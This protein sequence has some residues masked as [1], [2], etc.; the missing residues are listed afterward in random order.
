M[1]LLKTPSWFQNHMGNGERRPGPK[2][3]TPDYFRCVKFRIEF[4]GYCN[5]CK[6]Q[7]M[8][9]GPI[10]IRGPCSCVEEEFNL[11]RRSPTHS[12]LMDQMSAEDE[13][14]YSF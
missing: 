10:A 11:S 5:G 13:N 1:T 9:M 3:L 7:R 12:E 8:K 2:L 4:N 6:N 14:D